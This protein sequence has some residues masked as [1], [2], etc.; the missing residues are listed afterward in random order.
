MLYKPDKEP[1]GLAPH[2]EEDKVTDPIDIREMITSGEQADIGITVED[3]EK[4]TEWAKELAEGKH[5][6]YWDD[7]MASVNAPGE[8]KDK[9]QKEV[10]HREKQVKIDDC[11]T[12]IYTSGTT[13]RPKGCI[14]SHMNVKFVASPLARMMRLCPDDNFVC[15]LPLSHIAER[16]CSM[17]GTLSA[18][19]WFGWGSLGLVVQSETHRSSFSLFF[20]LSLF[21]SLSFSF[22]LFLLLSLSPSLLLHPRLITP[23]LVSGSPAPRPSAGRSP[24]PSCRRAPRSSSPCRVC[25]RSSRRSSSLLPTCLST[26]YG[27]SPPESLA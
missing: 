3:I 16:V 27:A 14:I 20:F 9:L 13:G 24:S 23:Q 4:N 25:G 8:A 17:V 18:G 21:L 7:I 12:L 5:I 26:S 1:R 2:R 6:H 19:G 15:Y 11:Y 22:S 10:H